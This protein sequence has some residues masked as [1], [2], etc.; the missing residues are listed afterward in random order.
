MLITLAS[1]LQFC[2]Q[3]KNEV[4]PNLSSQ[5]SGLVSQSLSFTNGVNSLGILEFNS[6]ADLDSFLNTV[7]QFQEEEYWYLEDTASVVY[8][9]EALDS[10]EDRLGHA[11]LRKKVLDEEEAFLL[12]GATD[13]LQNPDLQYDH[14]ESWREVLN[15][16]GEVMVD[17]YYYRFFSNN[18]YFQIKDNALLAEQVSYVRN[19]ISGFEDLDAMYSSVLDSNFQAFSNGDLLFRGYGPSIEILCGEMGFIGFSV[20]DF[21]EN[22]VVFGYFPARD[23]ETVSYTVS[24]GDGTTTSGSGDIFNTIHNYPSDGTYQVCIEG[25]LQSGGTQCDFQV[26]KTVYL[27]CCKKSDSEKPESVLYANDSR[28]YI[29]KI[30][31]K[32]GVIVF[33]GYLVKPQVIAKMKNYRRKSNGKWKQENAD[34]LLVTIYDGSVFLD[35]DDGFCQD[36]VDY[37]SESKPGSNTHIVEK[38]L[39]L[40]N[41]VKAFL[42]SQI[43]VPQNNQN[44]SLKGV[45]IRTD[46]NNPEAEYFASDNGSQKSSTLQLTCN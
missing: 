19:N 41:E 31:F 35:N 40:D 15:Q 44:I 23:V 16:Y 39:F 12:T 9:N 4:E 10:L 3:M 25:V 37:L 24:W 28:Q 21:G 32:T 46:Q 29:S 7:S 17:G 11:S 43:P 8:Q 14:D 1:G 36:Q 18:L 6:L 2:S 45:R 13:L 26:C 34:D 30:C 5:G 22:Y 33:N 42:F 27:G 38:A 20:Q